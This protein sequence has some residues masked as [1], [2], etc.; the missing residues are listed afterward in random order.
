MIERKLID[1][2]R[3]AGMRQITFSVATQEAMREEMQRDETVFLMGEDIARQGGIFGQFKD[4]AAEFGS[5]RVRDTPIS[6]TAIIGGGVG[7]AL[8]GMRPV[9][10]MHFADFI[11]VPMDEIFNQ[12]AKA[13]Y[14]FG[15]QAK[16]P[17]VLRAPD[18]M[19]RGGAA[20]HSQCV[21]AWFMHI[22]GI[23]VVIPSNPAD[24]KGLLKSAIRSDDPVLYF[25]H[26]RLFSMKGDVP[27]GEYVTPI[28]KAKV[29]KDGTDL[30]VVSYSYYMH[31]V[32]EAAEALDKDGIHVECVDL[33]TISP[34]DMD[35]IYES[36]RKTKKLM[37][38]HEA[39][40]QG[41][42]GAEVAAR[43]AEDMIDYLD[44]PIIR[45]GAPFVPIPYAPTLERLVKIEPGDIIKAV[46]D[47][48]GD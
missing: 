8:A 25:E 20:Q 22:P 36:L 45:L 34:L 23:K 40:K 4:L 43:T 39:V 27:E 29:A 19:T 1:S 46:K 41:G 9:V 16:V 35:T 6:E 32:L 42:V 37:I 14:M 30:T 47:L 44:A 3:N 2:G 18:G 5:E 31:N 26:K 12:M 11:G 38:V 33:R 48:L 17:L 24:A 15:G 28:G 13:R 21:E 7:A 10:D